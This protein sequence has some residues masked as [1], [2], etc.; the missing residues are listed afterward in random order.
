[1]LLSLPLTMTMTVKFAAE[2]QP[3]APWLPLFLAKAPS[4]APS[5]KLKA[6]P[7]AAFEEG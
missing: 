7:D 3:G 1:M 2:Q 4:T 5:A 6:N